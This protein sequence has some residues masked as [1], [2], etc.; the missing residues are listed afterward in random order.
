MPCADT[1]ANATDHVRRRRMRFEV[2]AVL[3]LARRVGVGSRPVARQQRRTRGDRVDDAAGQ[4]RDA[5]E[6]VE[7]GP[8]D[9]VIDAMIVLVNT[10]RE[11]HDG[12][13]E[14]REAPLIAATEHA[15]LMAAG[16][17]G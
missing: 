3:L 10:G 6:L 13:T 15:L 1:T 11:K 16:I 2:M 9:F 7:I 12:H 8:L 4:R 17:E 14:A 5:S